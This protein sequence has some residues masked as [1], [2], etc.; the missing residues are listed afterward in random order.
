M[1]LRALV[2]A[3]IVVCS[4]A[5]DT[6]QYGAFI[7][8]ATYSVANQLGFFAENGLNVVYSQVPNSTAAF[9]SILNG[10]YDILT[11]TVDNALNYRFNQNQNVTVIG[12]LDQGPDLVLASIPSITSVEQLKGKPI[13]VDS[14]VSGYAYLLQDVLSAYGLS[15]ANGD[16]YFMTVGGTPQRYSALVNQVLP[17]GTAVYA[18]IL[19]YPFTVEGEALSAEETPNILARISDVIAPVTSS[20][21]TI[22]Q[23][24]LSNKTEAALLTR[25]MAS[26]HAANRFLLNPKNKACSIQ[27]LA[28]QLGVSQAVASQEYA[29]ATN[30]VSGEISPPLNDF[31]VNQT[32]IMNDVAV[33]NKFG[34]F[35]VPSGF[36]F[37]E[38]LIPGTGKL[39]DYSIKNAAVTEYSRHRFH[40]NCTT[41]SSRDF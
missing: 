2:L 22:R 37:T 9:A 26:M 36:N 16:Y 32:G 12:Q 39:I 34:G 40:S 38:A 1:Q 25:F 27:A 18:T 33:R 3:S 28:K 24:S 19:T 17:N 11:A 6:V 35:T 7:A 10:E 41:P 5:L 13:I 31:T 21:F 8:T 29:S 20:A 15:L 14:P 23:S 4:Q 30:P